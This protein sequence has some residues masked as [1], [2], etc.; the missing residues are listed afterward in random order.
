MACKNNSA[1]AFI[2]VTIARII[3]SSYLIYGSLTLGRKKAYSGLKMH[4][5]FS[6]MVAEK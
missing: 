2:I 3:F 1:K 6:P 4:L 5:K